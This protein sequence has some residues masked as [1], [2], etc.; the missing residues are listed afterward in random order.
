M[1]AERQ[2][3]SQLQEKCADLEKRLKELGSVKSSL[4]KNLDEIQ[5]EK[6]LDNKEREVR[7]D[8]LYSKMDLL[9][10]ESNRLQ[11]ELQAKASL[12][13]SLTEE[14][15]RLL[16]TVTSLEEKHKKSAQAAVEL[17][18]Q[19][20]LLKEQLELLRKEKG[21]LQEEKDASVMQKSQ[22]QLDR[23]QSTKKVQELQD[24]LTEEVKEKNKLSNTLKDVEEMLE[25]E[26]KYL[27]ES[28]KEL[29]EMKTIFKLI[30]KENEESVKE[31]ETQI[32]EL[33]FAYE[34][35]RNKGSEEKKNLEEKSKELEQVKVQL[36]KSQEKNEEMKE[37]HERELD[38]VK[39]ELQDS[40]NDC[41]LLREEIKELKQKPTEGTSEFKWSREKKKL[42]HQL[43][44]HEVLLNQAKQ[45][46]EKVLDE[47]A[48]AHVQ[49]ISLES[50][51]TRASKDLAAREEE[52]KHLKTKVSEQNNEIQ[53]LKDK[54]PKGK[55]TSD[56][57]AGKEE[58]INGL[59]EEVL[60]LR[61]E[62]Q[63]WKA[64]AE[65]KKKAAEKTLATNLKLVNKLEKLNQ[66]K[67]SKLPDTGLTTTE[68]NS[69][70]VLSTP[71]SSRLNIVQTVS[72]NENPVS[73]LAKSLSSLD[74]KSLPV[75]TAT[76]T[77]TMPSMTTRDF[78]PKAAPLIQNERDAMSQ[79]VATRRGIPQPKKRAGEQGI[80]FLRT[81][82]HVIH[83]LVYSFIISLIYLQICQRQVNR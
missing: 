10:S 33:T 71:K 79:G 64:V 74:I 50:K 55:P 27:Q 24:K 60:K 38:K 21:L 36:Q 77:A 35:L 43:K 17:Q 81:F 58:E 72:N 48:Q 16:A 59:K 54:A 80:L 18:Q 53:K 28:N 12:I 56:D 76:M 22:E 34:E 15:A 5:K 3:V 20:D 8:D 30:E 11:D 40:N 19:C 52:I 13:T 73:P 75:S 39:F 69:N 66:E 23:E 70:E 63:Q 78:Q 2:N 7:E 65:E 44:E 68:T 82:I 83:L 41:S 9:T 57:L 67:G 4:Q 62:L 29:D 49:K 45:S 37:E 42:L 26:R 32:V 47:M 31:K 6:N 14:K 51:V 1:D 46:R 25:Q 61:E